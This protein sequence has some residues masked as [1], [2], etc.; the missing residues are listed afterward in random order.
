MSIGE[1]L[2]VSPPAVKP[3]VRL[4]PHTA[5]QGWQRLY[6]TVLM[7]YLFLLYLSRRY[8]SSHFF[9]VFLDRRT[10]IHHAF[11]C[12]YLNM[13]IQ[14]LGLPHFL[15]VFVPLEFLLEL[16]GG[17]PDIHSQAFIEQEQTHLFSASLLLID[18]YALITF[19]IKGIWLRDF[20]NFLIMHFTNGLGSV[21][22]PTSVW[23]IDDVK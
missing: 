4:S 22:T 9:S 7:L 6:L 20:S 16:T 13:R 14:K 12:P 3:Y 1:N 17:Y 5:W 10:L 8:Y 21:Y 15:F 18:L 19:P 11:S 23:P 2:S